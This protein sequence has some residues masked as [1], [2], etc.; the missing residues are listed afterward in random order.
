MTQ[1]SGSNSPAS[2]LTTAS[3]VRS[4]VPIVTPTV[5]PTVVPT[6]APSSVP[7]TTATT[8]VTSKAKTTPITEKKFH[9]N[10]RTLK[11]QAKSTTAPQSPYIPVD[12]AEEKSDNI[13][14]DG[15]NCTLHE[16]RRERTWL[17]YFKLEPKPFY[18]V[19]KTNEAVLVLNSTNVDAQKVNIF[20]FAIGKDKVEGSAS[21]TDKKQKYESTPVLPNER[22]LII[23]MVNSRFINITVVMFNNTLQQYDVLY[24][25]KNHDS[26]CDF[27][28]THST[29]LMAMTVEKFREMVQI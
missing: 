14:V 8:S 24:M 2:P 12:P 1:V 13:S 29:A 9:F 7:T 15:R 6:I 18:C 5:T 3:A 10:F 26:L 11:T 25:N 19:N 23:P 27:D 17:Q 28:I 22:Q 20:G 21:M 4:V 16:T